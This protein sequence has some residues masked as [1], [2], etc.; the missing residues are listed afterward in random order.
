[1]AYKYFISFGVRDNQPVEAKLII[2][3]LYC[4]ESNFEITLRS[5]FEIFLYR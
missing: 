2:A 1:M 5:R 3:K 4:S